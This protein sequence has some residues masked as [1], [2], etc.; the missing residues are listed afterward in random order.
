MTWA[1]CHIAFSLFALENVYVIS[2]FSLIGNAFHPSA[3]NYLDEVI[4]AAEFKRSEV[5]EKD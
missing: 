1:D 2:F 4:P 3:S 5:G